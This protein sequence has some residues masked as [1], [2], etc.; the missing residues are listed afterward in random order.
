M[1][2][3]MRKKIP[4]LRSKKGMTLVEILAGVVIIVIVFGSTL[5]AMTNGFSSTLRNATANRDA[6]EGESANE[7]IFQAIV[8][9]NFSKTDG[10][11]NPLNENHITNIEK[12][13][14]T[15]A[16]LAAAQS[17]VPDIVYVDNE[18]YDSD[19]SYSKFTVEYPVDTTVDRNLG[20]KNP[21]ISGIV[22]KTA[23]KTAS[24]YVTN[25]SFVPFAD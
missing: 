11:P 21:I 8:K 7:M 17:V 19:D 25:V 10:D 14:K 24:G 3:R 23:V 15:G 5:S 13:M 1:K 2:K 6:V 9:Q 20:N 4:K 18:Q 16:A 22:I 12:Y